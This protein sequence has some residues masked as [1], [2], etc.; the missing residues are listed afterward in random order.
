MG[1][2]AKVCGYDTNACAQLKIHSVKR[3]I[4]TQTAIAHQVIT[5]VCGFIQQDAFQKVFDVNF[6]YLSNSQHYHSCKTAFH[7]AAKHNGCC[8]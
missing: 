2:I 7:K 4:R 1:T 5:F 8:K 6:A 3:T